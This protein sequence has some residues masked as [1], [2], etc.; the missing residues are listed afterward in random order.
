MSGRRNGISTAAAAATALL[1]CQTAQAAVPG[2]RCNMTAAMAAL[3][4]R[5]KIAVT[6]PTACKSKTCRSQCRRLRAKSHDRQFDYGSPQTQPRDHM[7]PHHL[8]DYYVL[9]RPWM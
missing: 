6:C 8:P 1:I 7:G 2:S 4:L 9:H 5:G 3:E